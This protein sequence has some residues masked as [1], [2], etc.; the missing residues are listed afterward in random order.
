MIR[1]PPS[2]IVMDLCVA[3]SLLRVFARWLLSHCEVLI[4]KRRFDKGKFVT[5]G[6][7]TAS[8]GT[9]RISV[10][11]WKKMRHEAPRRSS[12]IAISTQLALS[13]R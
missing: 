12:D 10:L 3:R 11:K 13:E 2:K 5:I 7:E 6:R 4:P 1:L 8:G 9:F